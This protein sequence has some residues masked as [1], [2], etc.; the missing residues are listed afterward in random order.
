RTP[1]VGVIKAAHATIVPLQVQY[2]PANLPTGAIG[3]YV[4]RLFIGTYY[5]IFASHLHAFRMPQSNISTI[6][7]K[8]FYI[9]LQLIL[10]ILP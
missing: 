2:I 1:K 3:K 7:I 9:I 4:S 10:V 8:R 5:T 6:K